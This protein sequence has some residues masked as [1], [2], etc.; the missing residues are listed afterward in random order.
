ML[1]YNAD[2][3]KSSPLLFFQHLEVSAKIEG[4]V[5]GHRK[6]QTGSWQGG[7]YNQAWRSEGVEADN[8]HGHGPA[9]CM[10]ARHALAF[11]SE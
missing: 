1:K 9:R 6:W 3:Y 5:L 7:A 2:L 4:H 8:V 11:G 10:G